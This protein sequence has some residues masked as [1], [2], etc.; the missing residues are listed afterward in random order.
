MMNCAPALIH[1][2][3]VLGS[4]TVPAP[5]SASSPIPSEFFDYAN[6]AGNRHGDFHD[7]DAALSDRRNGTKSQFRR[8]NPDDRN[9][10]NFGDSPQDLNF[11]E[12]CHR[13]F[14]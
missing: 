1:C 14:P 3:A 5:M 11:A 12:R 9:H 6:R 7:G 10:A 8:V 13:F 2:S 4:N